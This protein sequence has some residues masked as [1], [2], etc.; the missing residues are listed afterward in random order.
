MA[1]DGAPPTAPPVTTAV[2]LREAA[3][4]IDSVV[5][6]ELAHRGHPAVRTAH[7]PVFQNLDK[8]GT[9][10]STLAQRAGMTKQAMAELVHYLERHGYV[11]R[12]PDPDDARAKLVKLTSKGRE[13]LVIVVQELVPL[14][15]QRL[16]ERLGNTRWH[17]LRNDLIQIRQLFGESTPSHEPAP[18]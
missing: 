4:A 18:R 8:E 1:R 3:T 10:V 17:Q 9:T 13:V 11:G 6:L 15:E 16:R 7:A 14:M 12:V 2:L 5:P